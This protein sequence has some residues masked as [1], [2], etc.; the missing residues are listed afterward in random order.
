MVC[1]T[2]C[3]FVSEV[4]LAAAMAQWVTDIA[5]MALHRVGGRRS[6]AISAPAGRCKDGAM[7]R[8]SP[9]GTII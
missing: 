4:L 3:A 5:H 7:S 9:R 8:A 1:M 2:L 6:T